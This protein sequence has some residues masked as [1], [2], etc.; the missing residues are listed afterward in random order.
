M[1]S[2]LL[3]LLLTMLII[4][5]SLIGTDKPIG[6]AIGE[7]R[8]ASQET[9]EIPRWSYLFTQFRVIVTYIRLL[10]FP[11]NQNLDYDYPIYHLF[12]N[13]QVFLSFVFSFIHPWSWGLSFLSFKA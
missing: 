12:S 10:F 9:E 13:P 4:P 3:P 8:E 7:L 1:I 5:L 11:I 2:Y 6:D